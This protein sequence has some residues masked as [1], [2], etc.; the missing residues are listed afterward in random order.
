MQNTKNKQKKLIIFIK[1]IIPYYNN[2]PNTKIT[3][4]ITYTHINTKQI[5]K[6]IGLFST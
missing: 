4:I 5:I 2:S 6:Y 3:H 1:V